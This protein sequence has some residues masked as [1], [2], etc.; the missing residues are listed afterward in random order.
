MLGSDPWAFGLFVALAMM[1]LFFLSSSASGWSD[2]KQTFA[3]REVFKFF[4]DRGGL[5]CLRV[6]DR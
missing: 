3:G 1:L 6:S 2:P 5:F 4:P